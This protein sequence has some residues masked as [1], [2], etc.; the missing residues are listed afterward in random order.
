MNKD[1]Q[2]IKDQ[3]IYIVGLQYQIQLLNQIQQ[4]KHKLENFESYQR[5]KCCECCQEA[6]VKYQESEMKL[7]ELKEKLKKLIKE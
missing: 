5:E 7:F 3:E 2:K 1:K 6:I 4:L